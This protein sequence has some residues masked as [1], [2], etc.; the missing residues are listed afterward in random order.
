M[1]AESERMP[2]SQQLELVA[3]RTRSENPDLRHGQSLF[4]A[5]HD[6]RPDLANKVRGTALDPFYGDHVIPEFLSRV[7]KAE[8]NA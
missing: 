4:N 5:L 2:L 8:G 1:L 3:G 6:L 7:D